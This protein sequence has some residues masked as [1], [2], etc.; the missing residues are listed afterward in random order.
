[1]LAPAID[2]SAPGG[3]VTRAFADADSRRRKTEVSAVLGR[4]AHTVELRY[5][6]Q[7]ARAV[8]GMFERL[9]HNELGGPFQ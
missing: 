4:L 6:S 1:M 3:Y 9:I 5:G 7:A 8:H 2:P